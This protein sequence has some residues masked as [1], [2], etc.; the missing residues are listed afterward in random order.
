MCYP[1]HGEDIS[2]EVNP[3]EADLAVFLKSDHDYIGSTVIEKLKAVGAERKLVAF[4][5]ATR[6]R[7]ETGNEI[8]CEGEVVGHVTSGAFSPSLNA[9]IG[10]GYVRT[11]FTEV[12]RQII[13][14]TTR[15][16]VSARITR[17]PIY[18]HGTCRTKEI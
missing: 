1:L 18:Q 13:I 10:M 17:K 14:R 9:S 7:P 2:P 5:C 8:L 12:D 6:R 11:G 16:E 3:I 15:A 4:V